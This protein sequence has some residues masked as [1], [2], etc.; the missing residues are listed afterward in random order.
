MRL[1]WGIL[2]YVFTF[3]Y[4]VYDRSSLGGGGFIDDYLDSETNLR[5][6]DGAA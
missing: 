6:P 3:A 4:I 1:P 2:L 5:S